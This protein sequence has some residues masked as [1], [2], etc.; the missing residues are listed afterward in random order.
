MLKVKMG[1]ILISVSPTKSIFQVCFV[2]F[3]SFFVIFSLAYF[4]GGLD[5]FLFV[6]GG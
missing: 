1:M 4:K 2:Y 5:Y 6:F 3:T